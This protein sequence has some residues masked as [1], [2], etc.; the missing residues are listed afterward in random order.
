M[1]LQFGAGNFLRAF[2]DLIVHQL[3]LITKDSLGEIVVVQSTGKEKADAINAANGNYH[4]AIQGFQ[5]GNT[6]DETIEVTSIGRALHAGSQWSKILEV[7][8]D[9]ELQIVFSLSLIHI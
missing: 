9:P 4:V 8:R 3:N 5:D 6:I 1:I 2:A 7:G